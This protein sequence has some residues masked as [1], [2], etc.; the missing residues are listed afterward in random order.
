MK[1]FST[2]VTIQAAPEKVWEILVNAA[3]YPAWNTTVERID[4]EIS[5]GRKISVQTKANPGRA[6]P[7]DV[8]TFEPPRTMVWTGG[9][10]LGLFKGERVFSLLPGNNATDFSMTETFNGLLS[11][12]IEKSLPDLQPAFDEFAACLKRRSEA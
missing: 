11:P 1:Q 12:L 10:P 3:D 8:A 4:G 5:L 6:F 7:L 9:L 2:R